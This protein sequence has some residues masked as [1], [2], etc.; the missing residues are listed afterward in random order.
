MELNAAKRIATILAERQ[1]EVVEKWNEIIRESLRGRLTRSEL[2]RQISE[3]YAA[4]RTA[5]KGGALSMDAPAA[6]ELAGLLSDLSASQAR[7]GFTV[8]E[9]AISSAAQPSARP[10]ARGRGHRHRR[11]LRAR[12]PH[13]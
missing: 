12:Q 8:S 10:A 3:L 9:T 6:A 13:R 7:R 2:T 1:D 4:L 11:T 5:L